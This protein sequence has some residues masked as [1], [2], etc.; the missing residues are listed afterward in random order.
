MYHFIS[1]YTAKVS[2]MLLY[3]NMKSCVCSLNACEKGW[4]VK[5]AFYLFSSFVQY[6]RQLMSTAAGAEEKRTHAKCR[7]F[8]EY[9]LGLQQYCCRL[10]DVCLIT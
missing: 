7:R 9:S 8:A 4:Q 3:S 6:P 10:C 5:F 1:G 2:C